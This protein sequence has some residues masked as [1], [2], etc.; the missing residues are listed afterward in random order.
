M[1]LDFTPKV[2]WSLIA[3]ALG[4]LSFFLPWVGFSAVFSSNVFGG[5]SPAQLLAGLVTPLDPRTLADPAYQTWAVQTAVGAG[6][7]TIGAI[8]FASGC[9]LV[10][11]QTFESI[12][13]AGWA[14]LLGAGMSVIAILSF[15]RS[16]TVAAGTVY[17]GPS[18]GLW[19][20]ITASLV[21]L[22]PFFKRES[23]DDWIRK[24]EAHFITQDPLTLHLRALNAGLTP[25]TAAPHPELRLDSSVPTP[26]PP[27]PA[28]RFC[29]ACGRWYLGGE[30]A[31]GR[32]G[33]PLKPVVTDDAEATLRP[34]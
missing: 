3:A 1:A 10:L 15:P 27:T 12:R 17:V 34:S 4:G 22:I 6:V 16:L 14:M 18:V 20:G 21:A 9:V 33:T 13:W 5:E 31:C 29:P 25:T 24:A 30:T 32:D 11:A 2:R 19:M 23:E 7:W 8:L 26:A 28:R